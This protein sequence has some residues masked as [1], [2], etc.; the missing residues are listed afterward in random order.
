M[1]F[2]F[3]N[4]P[5]EYYSPV[6]GGAISTLIMSIGR[7]LLSHGHKAT[8]LT[9]RGG[10]PMYDI[11]EVIPV[12]VRRR[13]DLS[14]LQ[15]RASS[16]RRRWSGWDW[17]YFEYYLNS[18]LEKLGRFSPAPDKVVVFNDL[19]SPSYIKRVLPRT[20][21]IVCLQNEWRTNFNMAETIR[22]TDLF[23]TC[24]DYIRQWTARTHKIPLDKFA[25]AHSG[26]DSSVFT[27]REDYLEPGDR[28]KVLFLG[29]IDPNKGPDLT[30][31]A[32]AALRAEGLPASLTV[33]GGLWFYGHG[34]EMENPFFRS[35]K[36][37][38]DASGA[39]YL[40]HVTRAHV[41]EIA[42]RHD[43]ACVLS[44]SNEPFGLVVLEAMAAGCAVISSDRGGLP[45]ACGGAATLVNPDDFEA[46]TAALRALV[47][48]KQF[49]RSAKTKSVERA[50]RSPWSECARVFEQ[51]A[52]KEALE[53]TAK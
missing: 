51:S 9:I 18:V 23:V 14:F 49:L 27:P 10:D 24:S 29:R 7:E 21:V 4:M 2:C 40:G 38:M 25:V 15:R 45:E 6:S 42:R 30:V 31:R 48:D 47:V 22:H 17:P 33:A 37:K 32:V 53:Y 1:N 12:E 3:V 16:L 20:E 36:A 44:R 26:V 5:I 35:L 52:R 46:V 43:I 39:E 11:G 13:E 28:V 19:V 41:P 50:A 34:K 8:V